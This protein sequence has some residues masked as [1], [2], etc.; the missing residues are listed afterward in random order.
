MNSDQEETFVAIHV[1]NE[2]MIQGLWAVLAFTFG[3]ISI[4]ILLYVL[5]VG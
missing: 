1:K 4:S 3:L 2:R 5:F